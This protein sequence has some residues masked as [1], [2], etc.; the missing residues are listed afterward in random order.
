MRARWMP[1]TPGAVALHLISSQLSFIMQIRTCLSCTVL[2]L[3]V[4]GPAWSQ[5][6]LPRIELKEVAATL[7]FLSSDA[8][9]GRDTPSPGLEEA[10]KYLERRFR[11]AGLKPGA[12]NGSFFSYYER[13]GR[14]I[15]LS[16]S[17]LTLAASGK[18]IE[19]IPGDDFRIYRSSGSGFETTKMVAPAYMK[20][21]DAARKG[22]WAR[23]KITKVLLVETPVDSGL[24]ASC[25]GDSLSL[26]PRSQW[27]GSAPIL[28]VRPGLLPKGKLRVSVA[29]P[30]AEQ[31]WVRLKNVV[32]LLP[33]G[34]KA[35]E[36]VLVSAHYDH[37]GVGIPRGSKTDTINNGADDDASGTTAVVELAEM[38]ASLKKE[39][40][41]ARSILFVCFSGEE[42]ELLGS[43]AMASSP[44][45]PLD[46]IVANVN[47]EMIGRPAKGKRKCA[48]VTGA[49]RSNFS[50][51]A[52]QAFAR[53]GVKLVRFP[54]A[55]QL[56]Y[57]SDNFSFAKH[58]VIAHSISAGSLHADYHRPTDEFKKIDIKHMTVIVNGLGA[59]V[60]EFANRADR[61]EPRDKKKEKSK[62]LR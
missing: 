62:K 16:S 27:E 45:V 56:Y 42:K 24:W 43:K 18:T 9:A 25:S 52:A 2:L 5:S 8:L 39:S 4:V 10:A 54:M 46:R 15:P 14:R 34:A 17:R 60:Y 51:I 21:E 31:A 35:Q 53:A 7:K 19:A 26:R 20:L 37:I 50:E 12:K 13:K 1:L 58:G 48:W 6:D 3:I 28:L 32:A 59:V 47:I 29:I 40:R 11:A 57:Q 44:P 49:S 55:E 41:P 23:K 30:P 61:P 36:Y 33:G 38:F 22:L